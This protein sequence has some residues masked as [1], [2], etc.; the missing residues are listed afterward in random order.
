MKKEAQIDGLGGQSFCT[1]GITRPASKDS[2]VRVKLTD[3]SPVW[4][5]K[6]ITTFLI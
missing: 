1:F 4:S 3:Q 2:L 5:S 6:A